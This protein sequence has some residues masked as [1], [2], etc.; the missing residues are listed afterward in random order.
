MIVAV[1]VVRLLRLI[2]SREDFPPRRVPLFDCEVWK[3]AVNDDQ[4]SC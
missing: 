3:N 4:E 2:V 1:H